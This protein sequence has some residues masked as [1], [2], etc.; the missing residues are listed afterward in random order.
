MSG[1]CT[2]I[3]I[4]AIML[5]MLLKV[6]LVSSFLR[7]LEPIDAVDVAAIMSSSAKNAIDCDTQSS[8]IC[9]GIALCWT[10]LASDMN[11]WSDSA[12]NGPQ[13]LT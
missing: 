4:P 2:S 7:M 9:G 5:M 6:P 11:P 13:R 12:T 10:L 3:C 1:V 8:I